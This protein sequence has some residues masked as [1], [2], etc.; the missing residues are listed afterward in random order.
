MILP[1]CGLLGIVSG[2]V[3]LSMAYFRRY[4]LP[5]PP[6]GVLNVSD[7]AIMIGTIIVLPFLYLILPGWLMIGV[8]AVAALS[9]LYILWEPVLHRPVLIW[10]VV[11]SL[12]ST[13]MALGQRGGLTNT[14]FI[15]VNNLVLAGMVVGITN[16]WA[17]SGM[18]ARDATILGGALIVYDVV[19]TSVTGQMRHVMSHL[20]A[21]PLV[22][23]FA[24]P[25][26]QHGQFVGI[27]LGDVLLATVFPLVMRK[28]FGQQAGVTAMGV[29]LL[30]IT[31][32]LV[33]MVIARRAEVFPLM[34]V[35]GPVMLLEYAYWRQRQGVER[36]TWQYWQAEPMTQ[37][38]RSPR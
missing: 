38:G 27:G 21:F 10:L 1:L 33:G 19:A 20:A 15:V 17:Q 12:V 11:V 28:A 25:I 26:G 18:R 2:V 13:D 23:L 9:T 30:T 31:L 34:V 16:I 14:Q 36:T 32:T 5:R 35:L 24:W 4:R 22:P 29:G 37:R 8:L 3:L 7:V 6:L